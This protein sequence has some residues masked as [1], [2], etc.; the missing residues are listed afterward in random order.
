VIVSF[1]KAL[2]G[3]RSATLHSI[4]QGLDWGAGVRANSV[5]LQGSD[6]KFTIDAMRASCDGKIGANGGAIEGTWTQGRP[7]PLEFRRATPETAWKDPSPHTV[8][9]V[10]WTQL[11]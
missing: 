1:D 3:N 2:D 6:L 5:T 11:P 8:R 7:L 9:F 10:T 4:D